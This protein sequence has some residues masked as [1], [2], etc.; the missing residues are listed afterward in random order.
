[1]KNLIPAFVALP[2]CLALPAGAVS[3]TPITFPDTIYAVVQNVYVQQIGPGDFFVDSDAYALFADFG[4]SPLLSG[5]PSLKYTVGM[6]NFDQTMVLDDDAWIFEDKFPSF[7]A[8]NDAYPLPTTY[9]FDVTYDGSPASVSLTLEP[10]INSTT[11]YPSP[12]IVSLANAWWDNGALVLNKNVLATIY[13]NDTDLANFKTGID[14]VGI[15]AGDIHSAFGEVI[16]QFT[17]G[18]GGD[19][20]LPVGMHELEVGY[21][22]IVQWVEDG[23]PLGLAG[24]TGVAGFAS[25]T[26]ITVYV[27]PEPSTYALIFGGLTLGLVIWQRRRRS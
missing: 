6:D 12:E 15:N 23:D 13:L 18:P 27:I 25:D 7:A 16:S 4:V 19:F 26:L 20:E 24:Y 5:T 3:P 1:M 14:I 22:N 9:T 17:I 21:I 2:F 11:F 8:L 10:D